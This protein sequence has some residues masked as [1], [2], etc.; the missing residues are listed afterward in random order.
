M[1]WIYSRG[2]VQRCEAY[3]ADLDVCMD[4]LK[5]NSQPKKGPIKMSGQIKIE[6]DNISI[7]MTEPNRC[8]EDEKDEDKKRRAAF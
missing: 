4:S 6:T 2:V 3:R 1:C 5:Y 7:T 8:D